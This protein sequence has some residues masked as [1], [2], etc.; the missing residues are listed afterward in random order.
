[1]E[2]RYLQRVSDREGIRLCAMTALSLK[3]GY[4]PLT[5]TPKEVDPGL[6]AFVNLL[7]DRANDYAR[8]LLIPR[9]EHIPKTGRTTLAHLIARV[10]IPA[11][12]ERYKYAEEAA[13]I[14]G[15][16]DEDLGDGFR[17]LAWRFVRPDGLYKFA[18]A[19]VPMSVALEKD[20]DPTTTDLLAVSAAGEV[21]F[22]ETGEHWFEAL[23]ILDFVLGIQ[24]SPLAEQAWL[25]LNHSVYFKGYDP[26]EDIDVGMAH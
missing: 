20:R 14:R 8:Q 7:N 15:L 23:Q 18:S 17:F 6:A 24:D 21:I 3:L 11:A 2:I 13:T 5:D 12:I 10:F 9:L 22:F 1:M 19:C 26:F 4:Q 16:D 25:S